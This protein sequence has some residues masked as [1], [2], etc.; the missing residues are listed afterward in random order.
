MTTTI[1][2]KPKKITQEQDLEATIQ[3]AMEKVSAKK[4]NELCLFIPYSGNRL[5]HF[6][7]RQLKKSEPQK[8]VSLLQEHIMSKDPVAI[9]LNYKPRKR[10]AAPIADTPP[11]IDT[12]D[13]K[14]PQN[15]PE[16]NPLSRLENLL[17]SFIQTVNLQ[18][19]ASKNTP[20]KPQNTNDRYLRTIQSQLIKAIRQ[21]RVD[22]ELWDAYVELT[23]TFE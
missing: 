14:T 5:H 22:H 3:K 1:E 10:K 23:E 19:S 12:K 18:T 16:T 11:P 13:N 21:K 15:T 20:P 4:E 7:F 17:E 6:T 9:K 8:L 2:K